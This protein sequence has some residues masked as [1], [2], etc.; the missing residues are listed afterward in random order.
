MDP[1][2]T[3]QTLG[4][5]T[6][7]L[8]EDGVPL[9]VTDPW[10]VGSAYWRSWWLEK[11]PTAD[12]IEDVRRSENVYVTHSHPD[13]FHYPSMRLI[14]KR[15]ILHPRF[16]RYDVPEFLEENGYSS[17]IMEP[18]QWTPLGK[19]AR[20]MSIP[21][22][23]DDSVLVI[24]TPKALILNFNDCVP[25]PSFLRLMAR[26]VVS[27]EKAVVVLKSYSPASIATSIYRDGK[28]SPMKNKEDYTKTARTIAETIGATHFVPF[29]S[30][31]FFNRN[32]ST[33]ANN[34]KV[35]FEDLQ[36]F[37]GDSPVKL[38]PPFIEMDLNTQTFESSYAGIDRNLKEAD[39][40]KVMLREK[41]EEEFVLP[42]DCSLRLE[43]YMREIFFLRI[44]F[45]RGIG[46]KLTTSQKEFFYDPRTRKL[47]DKIPENY[48]LII[49]LPDKVLYESLE[50]NVMTDI[51]ISMFIRVD[52]KLSSKVTCGFFLLMG[53]HDYGHFNSV[54][55]WIKF[56]RFYAPHGVP[57]VFRVK[58]MFKRFATD[59]K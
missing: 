43:K 13:H 47:T 35:V 5:A 48:D 14:G 34:D 56:V 15:E 59:S 10:L 53:L 55:D 58:D 51:G 40:E 1:Q 27:G 52:T 31:V 32:D 25:T 54:K 19:H 37:W 44:F 21:V 12:E 42:A 46:W 8:K 18:W 49:S 20:M 57:F 39:L 41:E 22:P 36:H 17:K 2:Y 6:L 3:L 24:D 50:N 45:R 26:R 16:P 9:M 23:I 29:A 38:C 28:A 4:H 30:Q 33:W 11:Y 7:M